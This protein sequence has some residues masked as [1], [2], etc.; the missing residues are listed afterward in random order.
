MSIS[1]EHSP[2]H[3]IQQLLIDLGEATATASSGDWPV[4]IANEPDSPD[5]L[6]SVIDTV[7]AIDGRNM[8]S[9]DIYEHYGVQITIR[10]ATYKLGHK[11]AREIAKALTEEVQNTVVSIE[12]VTGTGTDYYL[13]HNVTHRGILS[14]GKGPNSDRSFFTLNLLVSLRQTA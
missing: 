6:L 14:L 8:V 12:G 13:V 11:K 4:F 9:G 1:L 2:A 5:S 7:G 10:D 3:I